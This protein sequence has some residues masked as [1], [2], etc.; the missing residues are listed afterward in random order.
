MIVPFTALMISCNEG[1]PTVIYQLTLSENSV[2]FDMEGATKE[3]KIT[4]FPESEIWEASCEAPQDWFSFTAGTDV[5]CITAQPNY[6]LESRQAAI[7]LSSPEGRFKPYE[8]TV[9]QE[10]AYELDFSTS[11]S[12]HDFDS[13]GGEYTF[14]VRSNY[15]WTVSSNASWLDVDADVSKGLV[16]LSA[17]PNQSDESLSAI[18]SISV[19]GGEQEKVVDFAF[20]QGTRK[21]N[22]YYKLLGQWEITATQWY[23]SP[24]GSLNTLTYAPSPTDH[25]LLFNLKEGKYGKSYIM[26][27]FLYPGT[28][29]EVRY[30]RES[31]KIIIPFGWTVYSYDVYLYVTLVSSSRFSYA[32]LEVDGVVSEDYA[33]ISLDLPEVDGWNYVGFGL[34]TYNDNGVKVAVGSS[35][36]PTVFPMGT[37]IFK[38][39]SL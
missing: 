20:T 17:Q 31:G 11:A 15:D 14:T 28:S 9:V 27:D 26:S 2:V 29:L 3:L 37:I 24:N 6:S 19:A 8:V 36:H 22:P 21:D 35:M 7:T 10:A 18:V 33:S 23:Y 34:W 32:S 1:D 30:D 5:L 39:H 25:Y 4:P 12:D 16:T 13:E 38:K